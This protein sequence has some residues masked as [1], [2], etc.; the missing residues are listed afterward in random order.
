[1]SHYKK[2]TFVKTQPTSEDRD[3][4]LEFAHIYYH[5]LNSDELPY[6]DFS[7]I[8]RKRPALLFATFDLCLNTY[9]QSCAPESHQLIVNKKSDE[10]LDDRIDDHF[11][12]TLILLES[13]LYELHLEIEKNDSKATTV[14]ERFKSHIF[15]NF[16]KNQIDEIFLSYI[17]M[18]IQESGMRLDEQDIQQLYEKII[19]DDIPVI[20]T[21]DEAIAMIDTILTE[22]E[23]VNANSAF[24]L[25]DI[26]MVQ[27]S[28]MP[29]EA[30]HFSFVRMTVHHTEQINELGFLMLLHPRAEIRETLAQELISSQEPLHISPVILRRLIGMRN[31]VPE[32]E[33]PYIDTLIKQARSHGVEC[34]PM[35]D[36]P[37]KT[38]LIVST[39]DGGGA[40]I[41]WQLTTPGT[42][43][44][45]NKR[46]ISTILMKQG[47]GLRDF[48]HIENI[49]A[50]SMTHLIDEFQQEI[51]SI[52]VVPELLNYIIPH[53]LSTGLK[54]GTP[55]PPGLL[56]LAE[57]SG[58]DYWRPHHYDATTVANDLLPDYNDTEISIIL[59]KSHQLLQ[60]EYTLSWLEED[61]ILA[62]QLEEALGNNWRRKNKQA[63]A[64]ILTHIL[65]KKRT[66][67]SERLLFIGLWLKYQSPKAD[68]TWKDFLC[69]A[70]EVENEKRPFSDIGFMHA[71]ALE[72]FKS[73]KHSED[74]IF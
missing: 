62:E 4:A 15:D 37:K 48:T 72:N 66:L 24:D 67:W 61:A 49:S 32:N 50:K 6:I 7:A 46:N 35:P 19:D 41:L 2:F 36:K 17:I 38:Q 26:M 28:M 13:I 22:L 20:H 74:E 43:H 69:L 65:E 16:E 11:K 56:L 25:V 12:A 1:M 10:L 55:P 31:W 42:H 27:F 18:S 53:F 52:E 54:N 68:N 59:A 60:M 9:H 39:I 58:T 70:R 8:L 47:I 34:A 57:Q 33:R 29:I 71:L 44:K 51:S 73:A 5:S 23:K 14:W 21:R 3:L 45:K 63:P 30:Q 64:F 40:C